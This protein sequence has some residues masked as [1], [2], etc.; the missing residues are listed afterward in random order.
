M[1]TETDRRYSDKLKK[2]SIEYDQINDKTSLSDR[3]TI[4]KRMEKYDFYFRM[5]PYINKDLDEIERIARLNNDYETLFEVLQKFQYRLQDISFDLQMYIVTERILN[6]FNIDQNFSIIRLTLKLLKTVAYTSPLLRPKIMTMIN[7]YKVQAINE[8][9]NKFLD[10]YNKIF[11][12]IFIPLRTVYDDNHNTHSIID[13]TCEIAKK[14]MKEYPAIYEKRPFNHPFFDRIESEKQSFRDMDIK[15]LFA[16]IQRFANESPLSTEIW[17]RITEELNDSINH[18]LTGHI[19]RLVNSIRGFD[20]R[21]ETKMTDKD[22]YIGIIS[23]ILST[24]DKIDYTDPNEAL[25]GIKIVINEDDTIL[26]EIDDDDIISN[27]LLSFTKVNWYKD[28]N[29]KQWTTLDID[30]DKIDIQPTIESS[31][32]VRNMRTE[33]QRRISESPISFPNLD[34][35]TKDERDI[36]NGFGGIVYYIPYRFF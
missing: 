19:T 1:G 18:C 16:S 22:R 5:M 2:L 7:E 34:I 20:E 25:K 32:R 29:T 23:R 8:R 6:R 10:E 3:L 12:K 36:Y 28:F 14:I 21:F 17:S 4:Y 33:A 27:A 11:S 35:L 13:Q 26:R 9:N 24:S 15:S 31:T 30:Y